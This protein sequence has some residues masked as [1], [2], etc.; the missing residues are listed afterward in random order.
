MQKHSFLPHFCGCSM[1]VADKSVS[2]KQCVCKGGGQLLCIRIVSFGLLHLLLNMKKLATLYIFLHMTTTLKG[3]SWRTPRYWDKYAHCQ[4]RDNGGIFPQGPSYILLWL[5]DRKCVE[6]PPRKVTGIFRALFWV[7][8]KKKKT[9]T[10]LTS[11]KS[12]IGF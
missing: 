5:W 4:N 2:R 6:L 12:S 10:Q 3:N 11:V 7:K 8:Q 9:E 1:S